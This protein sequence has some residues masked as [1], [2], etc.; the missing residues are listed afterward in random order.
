[1]PV[2]YLLSQSR[3]DQILQIL[4]ACKEIQ[5]HRAKCSGGQVELDFSGDDA[6]VRRMDRFYDRFSRLLRSVD[7]IEPGGGALN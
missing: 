6:Q 1:M 2:C 3:G 5:A 7:S 4:E